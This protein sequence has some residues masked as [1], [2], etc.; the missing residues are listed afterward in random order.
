MQDIAWNYYVG[1]TTVHCIIKETCQVLWERLQPIYL[2][3][4]SK[5]DFERTA[6]GF[7]RLWNMPNCI[8]AVNGKH[9]VIQ[10]PKHSGSQFFSYKKTF[11]IVLMASCDAQYKFN[12]VDIGAAGSNHDGMVF[13]ES[14]FGSALLEQRLQLP[15]PKVLPGSSILLPHFLVADQAFPLHQNIMRP[16]PGEHLVEKKRI[17]NY[18]LSRARRCI[19]NAFGIVA[20][21]WRV[22]RK[23]IIADLSTCEEIVKATVVLHN[24]ILTEENGKKV[25]LPNGYADYIDGEGTLHEGRWRG[26]GQ[27]LTGIGRIGTNNFSHRVGA[28]RDL[29]ADYFVSD[30]GSVPWQIQQIYAG[31]LPH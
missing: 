27:H 20:Q 11:S 25:Y 12:M 21:R 18:R 5:N 26:T 4:P 6:A 13:R 30:A 15:N 31:S 23:T 7:S 19:E 24:F 16:Y 2:S 17:F 29:L 14:G 1:K 9:V 22:L 3:T 10:S 8:G 28:N